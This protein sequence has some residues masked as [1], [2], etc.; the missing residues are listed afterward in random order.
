MMCLC[1]CL[2]LGLR[3]RLRLRLC[4]C[5]LVCVCDGMLDFFLKKKSDV[6][7]NEIDDLVLHC[8]SLLGY[9][10]SSSSWGLVRLD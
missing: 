8:I 4:L 7:E 6:K 5:M 2:C 10:I 1:L 3:L 9:W